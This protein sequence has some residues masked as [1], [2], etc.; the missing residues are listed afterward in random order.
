MSLKN[1]LQYLFFVGAAIGLTYYAVKDIPFSEVEKTWQECDKTPIWLSGLAVMLSH[2]FRALRWKIALKPLGYTSSTIN[3]YLSILVGYAVNIA[4][5]R[6]GEV[7]RCM[8]LNKLEGVP[9]KTGVGTVISERI[10]DVI[11]LALM[12]GIAFVLK[13]TI[14][15]ET[16]EAFQAEHLAGAEEQS[17]FPYL[18]VGLLIT[19]IVFTFILFKS[20]NPRL[21]AFR[22]K[23]KDFALGMKDGISSIFKLENSFLFI[24]YSIIIWILYYFM[25][26]I[27]I[28]AF[29][30][31]SV[32]GLEGAL[33][34]LVLGSIAMAMPMPG[35]TGTYQIQ[36]SATNACGTSYGSVLTITF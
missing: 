9:V 29:A 5:P 2:W 23:V 15:L 6:G 13:F 36:A 19:A 27:V 34:V 32:L 25:A 10:V 1:I 16:I 33:M 7:A 18:K 11:F 4:V 24:L 35:G 30:E 12:I 21:I 3:S 28:Q 14:L 20:K 17:N 22:N 31:T 26:Y 8:T